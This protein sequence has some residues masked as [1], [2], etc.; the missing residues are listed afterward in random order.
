MTVETAASAIG[1]QVVTHAV[2]TWLGARRERAQRGAELV[3]LVQIGVRDHFK[4]RKLLRQLEELADQIA[5]RLR[6]VYE[7]DFRELPENERAAALQ[8]VADALLA[9]DLTDET[10]FA[11]DVDASSWRGWYAPGSRCGGWG[12]RSPRSSSTR[13]CWTRAA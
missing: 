6:P 3:D 13:R 9:A 2:G 4:Q 8:A 7:Q 11:A 5:E 12:W 1:T 10:L